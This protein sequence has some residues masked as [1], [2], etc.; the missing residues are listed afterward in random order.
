M[1]YNE[2]IKSNEWDKKRRERLSHDGYTCQQC[3]ATGQ[4]LDVHHLTYDRLGDERI[5]DL[6][7]LC[8]PCHKA[9]HSTKVVF[10]FCQTCGELLQIFVNKLAGGWARRTCEDGHIR[11]HRR[12]FTNEVEGVEWEY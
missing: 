10:D 3:G 5:S 7:S 11:E 9:E 6:V 12:K 4:P 1:N 2:Y 8:R